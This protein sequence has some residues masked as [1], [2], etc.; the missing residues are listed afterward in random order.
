MSDLRVVVTCDI[1]GQN[2]LQSVEGFGL[3]KSD[4]VE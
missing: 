2:S 4:I 1:E 3:L